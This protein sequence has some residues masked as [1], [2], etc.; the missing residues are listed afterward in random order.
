MASYRWLL[1]KVLRRQ[2]GFKMCVCVGASC[3]AFRETE[4]GSSK[5]CVALGF[6]RT[7]ARRRFDFSLFHLP[8]VAAASLDLVVL[9]EAL[10]GIV[11]IVKL[12]HAGGLEIPLGIVAGGGHHGVGPVEDWHVIGLFAGRLFLCV[13]VVV[14]KVKVVVVVA[15]DE[16]AGRVRGRAGEARGRSIALEAESRPAPLD[17]GRQGEG[18]QRCGR[19]TLQFLHVGDNGLVANAEASKVDERGTRE[20]TGDLGVDLVAHGTDLA[21]L[22]PLFGKDSLPESLDALVEGNFL[23]DVALNGGNVFPC[24][25]LGGLDPFLEFWFAWVVQRVQK[26]T[27]EAT[28]AK[29]GNEGDIA[30]SSLVLLGKDLCSDRARGCVLRSVSPG[31]NHLDGVRQPR[32]ALVLQKYQYRIGKARQRGRPDGFQVRIR[33]KH[34]GVGIGLAD[35][36]MVD[37]EHFAELLHR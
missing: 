30:V 21:V 6:L 2:N 31:A 5:I 14:V 36:E 19:T 34:H 32:S 28:V 35:D 15:L 13:I 3:A 24:L 22:F 9:T 20:E 12:G 33:C 4:L 16:Q 1:R 8:P 26:S 27:K 10:V 18:H 7:K 23:G 17:I 29:P 37:V 25:A 11:S